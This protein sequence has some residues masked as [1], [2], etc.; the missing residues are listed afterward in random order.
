MKYPIGTKLNI[1]R[2]YPKKPDVIIIDYNTF[3]KYYELLW[4]SGKGKSKWT[5][6]GID[7]H[8][9]RYREKHHF[10]DELFQI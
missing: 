7:M 6:K 9:V 3:T 2:L 4:V 5:E 8:L 1:K 10:D